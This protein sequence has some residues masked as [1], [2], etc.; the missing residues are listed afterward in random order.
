[1]PAEMMLHSTLRTREEGDRNRIEKEGKSKRGGK[2][3]KRMLNIS[4]RNQNGK[5]HETKG[6]LAVVYT[7]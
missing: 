5:N 6:A 1:M 2:E 3:K 4:F 7:T